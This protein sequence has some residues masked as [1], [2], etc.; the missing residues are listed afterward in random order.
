MRLESPLT[1]TDGPLRRRLVAL[2]E[3][4]RCV[5]NIP[6]TVAKQPGARYAASTAA[7]VAPSSDISLAAL[8]ERLGRG[9]QQLHRDDRPETPSSA[10]ERPDPRQPPTFGQTVSGA[11]EN[12]LLHA[13]AHYASTEGL[14]L[15]AASTAATLSDPDAEH[16]AKARALMVL[17]V[18]SAVLGDFSGPWCT[19]GRGGPNRPDTAHWWQHPQPHA[20]PHAQPPPPPARAAAAG[21]EAAGTSL[22][23]FSNGRGGAHAHAGFPSHRSASAPRH[24]DAIAVASSY[25]S[26]E[27]RLLLPMKKPGSSR[28]PRR[29]PVLAQRPP[30]PFVVR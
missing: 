23:T 26:A 20:Q 8:A 9:L 16:A 12:Q 6:H 13:L 25:G 10:R 17:A 29:A 15:R 3:A 1:A 27:G 2:D 11:S 21:A 5:P 22:P 18:S 4:L 7:S 19:W 14:P 28:G 30:P 24:R